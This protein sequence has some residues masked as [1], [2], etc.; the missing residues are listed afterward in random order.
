M[1]GGLWWILGAGDSVAVLVHSG[2]TEG[3]LPPASYQHTPNAGCVCQCSKVVKRGKGKGKREVGKSSYRC[4][5]TCCK[6]FSNINSIVL[7]SNLSCE[8]VIH[9]CLCCCFF[10]GGLSVFESGGF[11]N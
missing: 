10:K 4:K 7:F 1:A 11:M 8:S 9:R 5:D 3:S 6:S 2:Q